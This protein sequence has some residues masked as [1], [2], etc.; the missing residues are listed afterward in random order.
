MIWTG[1]IIFSTIG[2]AV[3]S[4]WGE[5]LFSLVSVVGSTVGG[6]VGIILAIKL[7][8]YWGIE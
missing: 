2:G 8:E 5:S 4:L 1:V 6:I 7:A 3:P